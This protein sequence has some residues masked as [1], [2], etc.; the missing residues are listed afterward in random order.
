MKRFRILAVVAAAI[1][2]GSL[3]LAS[4][5]MADT[6]G[7]VHNYG[8]GLC[9]Q[10]AGNSAASSTLIVQ[11]PCDLNPT[12]LTSN[13]PFQQWSV[14]CLNSGCTVFH[15]VNVGSGLCLRARGLTGPA[16]GEQIML[17]ACNQIT[18]L[19]WAQHQV[20]IPNRADLLGFTM[21]SRISGSTGYCLDVPGAS[22]A[23]GLALQLYRCNGSVAQI[24][25]NQINVT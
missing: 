4:P 14:S 1:M 15:W 13:N 10:P 24:W 21:E 7:P 20:D 11:E 19:N 18:D 6:F 2:A 9:L 22:G 12:T 5:A 23:V 8:D 25:A 3:A 16:N 17:W